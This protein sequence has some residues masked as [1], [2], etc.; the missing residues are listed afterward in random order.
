MSPVDAL[1]RYPL[2][3]VIGRRTLEIWSESGRVVALET[4]QILLEEGAPGQHVCVL[5]NGNIRVTRRD[6]S[7]RE[8]SLGVLKS[9]SVF[10]EYALLRPHLNTATCR[11]SQ[12]SVAFLLP[13]S[14]LQSALPMFRSFRHKLKDWLRLH[15][16]IHHFRHAAG[17]GFLTSPSLTPLIERCQ[18]VTIRVTHAV[19]T[20]GLLSNGW[21]YIR[22]GEVAIFSEDR[23][24]YRIL[25]PGDS[26]GER[27]LLD[28]SLGSSAIALADTTCWYLSR[29]TFHMAFDGRVDNSVQTVEPKRRK[30]RDWI[31]QRGSTDCGVAA[32]T[33]VLRGHDVDVTFEE[34]ANKTIVTERGATLATLAVTAAKLNRKAN[35]VRLG[36]EQLRY[37]SLPAVAHFRSGHY[38]ALFEA[39]EDSVV[40]GDP[41]KGIH[42]ELLSDFN[43]Q[44]SG[45]LLLF[46]SASKTRKPQL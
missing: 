6:D 35:A 31:S 8:R 39:H 30:T 9:G 18:E 45:N 14:D 23:S 26:L 34:V 32:L 2:F 17:L 11:A 5:L 36:P 22:M 41:A 12:P 21:L 38:V 27:T 42:R 33:M 46:P 24:D 40:V 16:L 1:L 15:A 19:Q 25:G 13:L 44:W 7:G 43:A 37:A 3:A 20:A 29:E 4:G 10:G 28:G